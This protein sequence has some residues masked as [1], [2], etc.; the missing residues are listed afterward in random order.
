MPTRNFLH[1][2]LL[3]VIVIFFPAAVYAQ[4][5]AESDRFVLKGVK[6]LKENKPE[7]AMQYFNSAAEADKTNARAYSGMAECQIM[8]NNPPKAL[9]NFD[10]ALQNGADANDINFRI[11]KVKFSVG[12]HA[13]VIAVL[14]KIEGKNRENPEYLYLLGESYRKSG[15]AKSAEEKLTQAAAKD[16]NSSLIRMSLGR[17]YLDKGLS[18]KAKE[19]FTLAR[20]IAANENIR[21]EADNMI[22]QLESVRQIGQLWQLAIPAL[23]ILITIPSYLFLKKQKADHPDEPEEEEFTG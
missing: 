11:A 7:Q 17:I 1:T 5:E 22:A 9:E 3:L 4:N 16:P 8:L 2:A 12:D 14:E 21:N 10:K 23:V 6:A 20:D 19:H 15:N 13:G 18:L